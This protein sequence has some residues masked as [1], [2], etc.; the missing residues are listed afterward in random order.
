[1]TITVLLNLVAVFLALGL[2]VATVRLAGRRT[3][4]QSLPAHEWARQKTAPEP[5]TGP[6]DGW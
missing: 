1:M 4:T 2:L 6:L 5:E 3:V